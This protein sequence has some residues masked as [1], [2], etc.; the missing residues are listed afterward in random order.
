MSKLCGSDAYYF[1]DGSKEH[2]EADMLIPLMLRKT[3]CAQMISLTVQASNGVLL[4]TAKCSQEYS[5]RRKRGQGVDRYTMAY[6]IHDMP[7]GVKKTFQISLDAR[8]A[9]L[10]EGSFLRVDVQYVDPLGVL[11]NVSKSI[12]RQEVVSLQPGTPRAFEIVARTGVTSLRQVFQNT[13]RNVANI[14]ENVDSIDANHINDSVNAAIQ[15]GNNEIQALAAQVLLTLEDSSL[16]SE[17]ESFANAIAA[18]LTKLQA[19]VQDNAAIRGKCWQ[20][21][22]AMSSAVVRELPTVTNVLARPQVVCPLPEMN[23]SESRRTQALSVY[24]FGAGDELGRATQLH[25]AAKDVAKSLA[26]VLSAFQLD[27]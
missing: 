10:F 4:E 13:C 11:R 25:N 22:K 14:L 8:G 16:R 1:V 5:V 19:L 12:Q 26:D 17:F 3:A 15:A 24:V 7:T 2:P 9:S 18:N 21:A 6:F 23:A 20:F 27:S